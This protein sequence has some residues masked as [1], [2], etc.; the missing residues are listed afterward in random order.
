MLH[1]TRKPIISKGLFFWGTFEEIKGSHPEPLPPYPHYPYP[2]TCPCGGTPTPTPHPLTPTDY[3]PPPTPFTTTPPP[4][5][6][7]ETPRLRLAQVLHLQQAHA[8]RRGL[9]RLAGNSA[10]RIRLRGEWLCGATPRLRARGGGNT[11]K[12]RATN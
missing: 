6:T 9:Q 5:P 11:S 7:P 2:P 12:T 1:G 8:L 10:G 4:T 3:P